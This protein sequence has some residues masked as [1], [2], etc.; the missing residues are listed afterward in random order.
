MDEKKKFV[1]ALSLFLTTNDGCRSVNLDHL[2]Y[3][4]DKGREWLYIY[5]GDGGHSFKK[6]NITT[7]SNEAIALA[8]FEALRDWRSIDYERSV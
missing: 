2:E 5:V 8:L 3:R 1:E 4:E 6:V 7:N